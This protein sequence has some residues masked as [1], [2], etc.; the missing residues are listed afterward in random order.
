MNTSIIHSVCT[1]S[2]TEVFAIV[3]AVRES[4]CFLGSETVFLDVPLLM[5][6]SQ[7]LIYSSTERWTSY[8][9]WLQIPTTAIGR[10]RGNSLIHSIKNNRNNRTKKCWKNTFSWIQKKKNYAVPSHMIFREEH[11][12]ERCFQRQP[13]PQNSYSLQRDESK[14]LNF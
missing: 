1:T 13:L 2:F 12:C 5:R 8:L 6:L 3:T 14:W 4:S 11:V 9:I 10:G 7:H